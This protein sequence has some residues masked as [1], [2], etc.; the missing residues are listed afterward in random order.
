MSISRR[1]VSKGAG[2][3][4]VPCG[5]LRLVFISCGEAESAPNCQ[6][7]R[8]TLSWP[9]VCAAEERSRRRHFVRWPHFA[10]GAGRARSNMPPA[11][12]AAPFRPDAPSQQG[13]LSWPMI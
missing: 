5:P 3:E 8:P 9:G 1:E 11:A 10:L 12:F 4:F 13:G 2:G 6:C 7:R